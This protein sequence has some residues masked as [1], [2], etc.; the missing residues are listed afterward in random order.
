[1]T[2]SKQKETLTCAEDK[3]HGFGNC[4]SIEQNVSGI[5][6]LSRHASMPP[7]SLSFVNNLA[8]STFFITSILTHV[9]KT[10]F[11][12]AL[13]KGTQ[14]LPLGFQNASQQKSELIMPLH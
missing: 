8:D 12:I 6:T 13:S 11:A 4:L 7:H 3:V 5:N 2:F 1:M 10:K 9:I 14:S